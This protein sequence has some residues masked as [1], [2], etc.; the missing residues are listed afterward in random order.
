MPVSHFAWPRRVCL[1]KLLAQLKRHACARAIPI[2]FLA[3]HDYSETPRES[4]TPISLHITGISTRRLEHERHANRSR[5]S[6]ILA[7]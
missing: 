2:F 6:F 1:N 4:I 3:L 7:L 5:C